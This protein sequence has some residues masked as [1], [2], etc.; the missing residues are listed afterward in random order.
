MAIL[1]GGLLGTLLLGWEEARA[2]DSLSW[3]RAEPDIP[4]REEG[5]GF[6]ITLN[7]HHADQQQGPYC[8][9]SKV[10]FDR[11]TGSLLLKPDI[12]GLSYDEIFEVGSTIRD[13]KD[14]VVDS[15]RG[16]VN[17]GAGLS[18]YQR[19]VL[20]AAIRGSLE[21]SSNE[22]VGGIPSRDYFFS[23]FQSGLET[24][25]EDKGLGTCL[26]FSSITERYLDD[27]GSR[28]ASV[29]GARG[30]GRHAYTI[31]RLEDGKVAVID[32]GNRLLN[33]NGEAVVIDGELLVGDDT[34][35][36]LEAYQYHQGETVFRHRLYEDGKFSCMIL[37][38]EGEL[39]NDF[40]G[41]DGTSEPLKRLLLHDD[42][43]NDGIEIILDHARYL[44]SVEVNALGGFVKGGEIRGGPLS[45]LYSMILIQIGYK[46]M[47]DPKL[48]WLGK[49]KIDGQLSYVAGEIDQRFEAYSNGL[50]GLNFDLG[51]SKELYEGRLGLG[52]RFAVNEFKLTEK[53]LVD[54]EIE[55]RERLLT[56]NLIAE[57][58]ASNRN[59]IGAVSIEPY[60]IAGCALFPK[61]V[62]D[63]ANYELKF[64]RLDA[65]TIFGIGHDGLGLSLE[66]YYSERI[67]ER[68]GEFG[69]NA[70]YKGKNLGIGVKGYRIDSYYDLLP[71]EEGVDIGVY[72][73]VGKWEIRPGYKIEKSDYGSGNTTE[74]RILGIGISR[75]F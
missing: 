58:G 31:V 49:L 63:I 16:L 71:D 30:G 50:D 22:T 9:D 64:S 29:L 11:D 6:N 2:D 73:H 54:G 26:Q 37:T 13:V 72:A 61:G 55:S 52:L 27:A 65:G 46:R 40:I 8:P 39:F 35:S 75:E 28:A 36:A 47:F 19:L 69:V 48:P 56:K 10:E 24:G 4:R 74:E 42:G 45:P 44:D 66:P 43:G 57:V 25:K 60:I 23:E 17:R 59:R 70:G 32:F 21:I 15:Y 14:G 33:D 7:Y 41:F 67:G 5:I 3:L 53:F 51:V 38:E 68:E 20:G 18:E 62:V 12:L 1:A 34:K